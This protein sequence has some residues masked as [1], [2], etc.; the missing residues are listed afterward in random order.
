MPAS[1][2]GGA[3]GRRLVPTTAS[4]PGVWQLGEV[5]SGRRAGIWPSTDPFWASTMLLLRMDGANNSTAFTDLSSTPKAVTANGDAKVSTAQSQ[6]GGASLLLDGNGDYLSFPASA[7][8]APGTG[9]FTVECWIRFTSV[10]SSGY[11]GIANT[12]NSLSGGTTTQ[13]HFG[14]RAGFGLYLG[15]HGNATHAY[16][17]WT[18]VTDTWYSVAAV[19]ASGTVYLFI[20]GV[21]QTVVNPTALNGANFSTTTNFVVGVIATPAYFNGHIDEFRLTKAARFTAS[22]APS[23][24]PFPVG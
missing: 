10:P 12:M 13:W 19:R 4:A 8:F 23:T 16:S 7:D 17:T 6:F 24:T 22:Y 21:S 9:D 3:I 2:T 14:Y 15:Q 18:P 11:A 20:N 5:E 1:R